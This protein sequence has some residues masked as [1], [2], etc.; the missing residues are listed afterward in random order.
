MYTKKIN[1][2][3]TSKEKETVFLEQLRANWRE[4]HKGDAGRAADIVEEVSRK[5]VEA[6]H[7][8]ERSIRWE[9]QD[10]PD[11]ETWNLVIERLELL[12][13]KWYVSGAHTI[14]SVSFSI[15]DDEQ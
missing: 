12:G 8:G 5:L 14:L 2:L 9:V 10:S 11:P 1:R 3:A 7:R 6:S 13:L 15:D 4:Y